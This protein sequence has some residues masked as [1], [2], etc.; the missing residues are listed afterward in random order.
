MKQIRKT[1]NNYSL[2]RCFILSISVVLLLASFG[3]SQDRLRTID[4]TNPLYNHPNVPIEIV[5]YN[6]KGKN[7]SRGE[8]VLAGQDWLKDL[9][10][11]IKNISSKTIVYFSIE[12]VVPK[13]KNLTNGVFIPLRFGSPLFLF[14]DDGVATYTEK[15]NRALL[16]PGETVTV[17]VES[18]VLKA[19]TRS[20]QK[21]GAENF[22]SVNIHI[23]DVNFDD[24]SGWSVGNEWQRDSN[25]KRRSSISTENSEKPTIAYRDSF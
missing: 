13:S 2:N 19:F 18:Y 4:E 24:F 3:Y 14:N 12:L 25:G 1:M 17:S 16:R 9:T 5:S 23:Y 20:L 10:F 6:L 8:K 21:K 7:F 22:D 11:T 15:K